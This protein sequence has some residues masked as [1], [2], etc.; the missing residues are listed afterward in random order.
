MSRR[1]MTIR[2]VTAGAAI[3]IAAG[4]TAA[5]TPN[6]T[7]ADAADEATNSGAISV[8]NCGQELSFAAPP[9]RIVS[10]GQTTTEILLALGAADQMVGTYRTFNEVPEEYQEDFDSVPALAGE[11]FAPKEKTLA[12]EPDL[13]VA[14]YF[15]EEF[16]ESLG[17]PTKEDLH[18]IGAQIWGSTANCVDDQSNVT[19][20]SVYDDIETL[21]AL[22]GRPERGK[23]LAAEVRA[24]V[25][26]T[27]RA[28]AHEDPVSVLAYSNGEGP[29]GVQGAGLGSAIIAAAGGENVFADLRQ[30]FE[31][32]SVENAA[33]RNP[34]AFITLQYSPGPSAEDKAELLNS[35]LPTTTAAKK[36]RAVAVDDAGMGPGIRLGETV[37]AIAEGLHS[38][39]FD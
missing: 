14:N 25:E 32:V 18:D 22:V 5:C 39:A 35:T 3:M 13:V 12:A 36:G 20:E 28:V 9:E 34:E 23:E 30:S 10:T 33:E 4:A 8:E 26:K 16:D 2:G 27:T 37:R 21:G 19:L 6:T 24:D 7:A 11:D 1:R 29:L 31:Q 38:G 15:N 17:T